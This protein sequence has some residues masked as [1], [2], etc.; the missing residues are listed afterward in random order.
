M[1]LLDGKTIA[2]Q[3]RAEVRAEVMR[4]QEAGHRV[5]HLVIILVGDDPASEVYVGNKLR[6][7]GGT[8]MTAGCVKFGS[9]V[10]TER[11]VQEVERLNADSTVDGIVVQLPLPVHVD[12]KRVTSA[13][14]PLKDVDSTV[15]KRSVEEL[16]HRSGVDREGREVVVSERNIPRSLTGDMVPD[17]AIVID[18]G[19]T[20]IDDPAAEK[21]YRIVGD[22]DMESVSRKAAWLSPVP[23]G[24]GPMLIAV[25]LQ[26]VLES[27]IRTARDTVV[28]P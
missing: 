1:R 25:L 2:A 10:T 27:R 12:A 18:M 7:A 5:P 22:A 16:L 9:G 23:G 17:G 4:L 6:A 11:L 28:T 21:G 14:C 13:V 3:V 24:V 8:G 15:E 20:R 26:N 19:F